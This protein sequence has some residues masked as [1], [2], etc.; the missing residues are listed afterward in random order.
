MLSEPSSRTVQIRLDD[1]G[2]TLIEG[3]ATARL[4]P[5]WLRDQSTESGQIEPTNRQRLFT[6]LDIP[7]DLTI[8]AAELRG[9]ELV[10]TFSDGH[11]A[12]FELDS[13]RRRVGWIE[14]PEA[15]P[16]PEPWT[17][18]LDDFPYVDWS[19]IGWGVGDADEQAVLDYLTAFFRHGYVV[20]RN[21]PTEPDTVRR[22]ANRLGYIVGQNFGWVFDVRTE[23]DPTDLAY[24]SIGLL[25]H[26]DQPYRRPVPGIQLLH[27]LA[28]EAPGGDSTLVDGLAAAG[29]IAAAE[30]DLH[31]A[32][33]STEVIYPYDMGTDTVV[34]H[35][36]ILEYDRRGR[37]LRMMFNTKL[38]SPVFRSGID[39]DAWYAGRRWL[40]G[41]LNDPSH[42][43]TFRLEPGDLM[44]MDNHRVLHGRTAFDPSRGGRH[45]QGCYIEH[46]GPDTM[47]R[48]AVRSRRARLSG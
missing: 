7:A 45:L 33:A 11:V 46:D 12:R 15:P 29:A 36:H 43:V 2:A 3:A 30:P 37:F 35:G 39:L 19:G 47:Y 31:A 5:N 8:T 16:S 1:G 23:P 26:T 28:N 18:P 22:V 41:W 10:A 6:P 24:T 4:H 44:F 9:A 14:D 21:T 27:C 13:I 40:V 38:D 17:E 48:L 25:A 32:L 34:N 20:F 42:Q